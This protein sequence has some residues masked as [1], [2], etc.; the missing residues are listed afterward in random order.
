M[1]NIR[2]FAIIAHIDHGKSTLADRFIQICGGLTTREMSNQVLDSMDLEKE[3][4]ITIKAQSVTIKY[5]NQKKMTFHLNF[6]DTPGHVDFTYEV[7]RSLNACEGALLVID[8]CQGVEAQTLATCNMALKMN[9]SI[10][11][12]LNKIDLPNANANKVIQEIHDMIGINTQDIVQCSAKNGTGI[13][14]LLDKIIEKIPAPS[15][16]IQVTLQ[17][18]I[19]DSW[20]DNYLGVISLVCIKNGILHP[21]TTIIVLSTQNNYTVHTVGIFTPKKKNKKYLKCGEIGWMIC[22]IKDTGAFRVGDTITSAVNP[23]TYAIPGFQKIRPKIF[24]GL[25]PI[26]TDKHEIFRIALGKL[27]LNDSALYYEPENSHALGSGFKCGF[28][29]VLHMEIIQARL[30]REYNLEII[31]T[32]PT[33]M[34]EIETITKKIIYVNNPNDLNKIKNIREQREPIAECKILTPEKYIGKI[35]NLCLNK[36]GTQKNITYHT[37]QVLLHFDIPIA[38]IITNFFDKMKSLSSGYASLEYHFKCFKKTDIVCLDILINSVKIDALSLIM[39]RNNVY[40]QSRKIVEKIKLLL[41]RQQFNLA[42]QAAI[43]NNIIARSTI[44]QLRKNVLSKC[45]GGDIS[46]KKKLLQKQKSGKKK[47]KKIGNIKIPK[48][49]FFTILS[50]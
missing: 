26:D 27:S 43:G 31:S 8:A 45:Y 41:P 49:A 40:N 38:E 34:Y 21:G 18:L 6:I 22:G 11:P 32:T 19:I 14:P 25:F 35:I 29:G 44:Q 36:R 37:H 10:I 20:F 2:N 17:A 39:H 30:E 33:V 24:A 3:R 42:I 13:I 9:L 46:R 50:N 15:G 28:L 7:S 1:K 4:G 47:M 16:S 48:K 5:T 12:V 23:T